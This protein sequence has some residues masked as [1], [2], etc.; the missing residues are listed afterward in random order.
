L[1]AGERLWLVLFAPRRA[2]CQQI[3]STTR[4]DICVRR[5]SLSRGH[6]RN[7]LYLADLTQ[8]T[9]VPGTP[10]SW[11][12]PQSVTTIIGSLAGMSGATVAPRSG[13]LATVTSEF[14]GS[15]FA[16]LRLP[17]TSGS[18]TPAIVDYAFVSCIDDFDAGFYPHTLT[19]YT[20]PN[21]GKAYTV[22]AN[23]LPE[24]QTRWRSWTWPACSQSPARETATPSSGAC[25]MATASRA[26]SR[27]T[28]QH[29]KETKRGRWLLPASLPPVL[30]PP[31][32]P[33]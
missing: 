13:H 24:H 26:S 33:V 9:F 4:I 18:G 17:A 25:P 8:A 16:V 5:P 21:D 1:A 14:G 19:A 11:S 12:G 2:E 20:S 22:F 31:R 10:G 15:S 7:D 29:S 6:R 23:W 27:R 28:E 3:Q 32:W 30:I